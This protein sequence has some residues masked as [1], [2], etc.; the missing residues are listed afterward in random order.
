M[1]LFLFSLS[2][3]FLYLCNPGYSL[4]THFLLMLKKID[5]RNLQPDLK[6]NKQEGIKDEK[7]FIIGF[8]YADLLPP[9]EIQ[10][11]IWVHLNIKM[12]RRGL[13]VDICVMNCVFITVCI[14]VSRHWYKLWFYAESKYF[15]GSHQSRISVQINMTDK[16]TALQSDLWQFHDARTKLA[17][18]IK[19]L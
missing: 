15:W 16:A 11:E 1:Y 8:L 10:S 17:V 12:S 2:S 9:S 5:S 6:K 4:Y 7:L 3:V 18:Q 14:W 13:P 19:T